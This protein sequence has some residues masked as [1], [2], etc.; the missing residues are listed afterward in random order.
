MV[1]FRIAFRSVFR[2]GRRSAM[3]I[4]AVCVGTVAT[5]LLSALLIHVMLEF[6]TSAVRRTGHLTVYKRGYFDFGSANPAAYGIDHPV[7][8]IALIRKDPV[9]RDMVT[10]VTSVQNVF[11]IAG[12]YEADVSKTFFGTGVVPVDRW[13]MRQWNDFDILPPDPRDRP[14]ADNAVDVGIT[15]TGLARILAL[16]SLPKLANCK[17]RPHTH[18]VIPSQES[19]KLSNDFAALAASE[20]AVV[21]ST[22]SNRKRPRLDLLAATSNGA[23]NVVSL[24]V[25]HAEGQGI[26]E[27]ND[28]YIVMNI[29][30]AQELV[31]GQSEPKVTGIV[32]QLY[33]TKDIEPARHRLAELFRSKKLDLEVRDFKE[34]TP[35]YNQA[36][37][38]FGLL[39]TFISLIL[40]IIV[41]FTIVNTM[42]MNIMERTNEIGTMR[43]LGVQKSTIRGQFIVEGAIIGAL[44]ATVGVILAVLIAFAINHSG[45][46]WSPPTVASKIPL[47]LYLFGNPSLILVTWSVLIALSTAASIWPSNRA[48]SLPVVDALRHA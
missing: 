2:N 21:A 40:G 46:M 30:L 33:H 1:D 44:G 22:A 41:S 36:L 3:T 34:L 13:R 27:Y 15:G 35:L 8:L 39:I 28:N 5:L 32:T 14:L 31:Y 42:T 47:Q 7:S 25:D 29:K 17:T 11:G 12:N 38:F 26:K 18:V 20:K 48:A 19:E 9:L 10:V 45:L 24:Y 37:G 4:G 43:A 16:C 6:Q 23:P